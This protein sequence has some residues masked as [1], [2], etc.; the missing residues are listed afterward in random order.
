MN[1]NK[2]NQKLI[3]TIF[4]VVLCISLFLSTPATANHHDILADG[5]GPWDDE[6]YP[7]IYQE[8]FTIAVG[9]FDY[10]DVT[11]NFDNI[12]LDFF[13]QSTVVDDREYAL[14]VLTVYFTYS[15]LNPDENFS[16]V[17]L[18]DPSKLVHEDFFDY[19][20][21]DLPQYSNW[22]YLH[23]YFPERIVAKYST[24]NET[25]EYFAFKDFTHGNN[26]TVGNENNIIHHYPYYNESNYSETYIN[27]TFRFVLYN[28]GTQNASIDINIRLWEYYGLTIIIDDQPPVKSTSLKFWLIGIV[29]LTGIKRIRRY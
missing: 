3:N 10:R 28:T 15:N 18:T 21:E 14:S 25:L 13:G 20:N 16:L 4:A 11:V 1:S 23:S 12:S 2:K 19:F 7:I 17:V 26:L 8:N 27:E 6:K 22:A 24:D 9:D 29:I 5:V